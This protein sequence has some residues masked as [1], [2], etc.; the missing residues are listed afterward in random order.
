MRHQF[1]LRMRIS[2]QL[3]FNLQ[4][5]QRHLQPPPSLLIDCKFLI[6]L[7][8]QFC[9]LLNEIVFTLTSTSSKK[10]VRDSQMTMPICRLHMQTSYKTRNLSKSDGE[11]EGEGEGEAADSWRVVWACA[12]MALTTV[13]ERAAVG[14]S[15]VRNLQ[16]DCR[17]SRKPLPLLFN[18]LTHTRTQLEPYGF[19]EKL[20]LISYSKHS[21]LCKSCANTHSNANAMHMYVCVCVYVG[22]K[23]IRCFGMTVERMNECV[24][25]SGFQSFHSHAT[26]ATAWLCC[27]YFTLL[28]RHKISLYKF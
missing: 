25:Y 3:I 10:I 1:V 12:H 17:L 2:C 23:H 4:N 13:N 6:Y 5:F 8:F 15:K 7:F 16:D 27:G 20:M 26:R 21:N 19:N 14:G 18:H 9:W 11:G 28:L 24:L 22:C